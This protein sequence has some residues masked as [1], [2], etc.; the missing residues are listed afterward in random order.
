MLVVNIICVTSCA[1]EFTTDL[2]SVLP[3]EVCSASTLFGL[4]VKAVEESFF[5]D[6]EFCSYFVY[7]LHAGPISMHMIVVCVCVCVCT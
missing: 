2:I 7:M 4:L 3:S 1:S 6:Q 5:S